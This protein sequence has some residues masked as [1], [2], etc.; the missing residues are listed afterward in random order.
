M[1]VDGQQQNGPDHRITSS[2]RSRIDSGMVM[3][4]ALAV[5]KLTTSSNNLGSSG[6]R[7]LEQL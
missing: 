3:P 7:L 1:G 2:A 4:S 5:L 6:D